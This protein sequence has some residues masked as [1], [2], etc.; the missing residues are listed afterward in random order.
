MLGD[1]NKD[2][3]GVVVPGLMEARLRTL[4]QDWKVNLLR[5]QL[6]THNRTD[7]ND[8]REWLEDALIQLDDFLTLCDSYVRDNRRSMNVIVDLHRVPGGFDE[9]GNHF[10][11]MDTRNYSKWNAEF[12]RTWAKIVNRCK[13]HRCVIGYDLFN[14][15]KGASALWNALAEQTVGEIR[16]RDRN[17][18]IVI[19]NE[20][21]NP[22]GIEY[23]IP[24][25]NK[26]R[27]DHNIWYSVHVY[28]PQRFTSQGTSDYPTTGVR[29]D[30]PAS[31]QRRLEIAKRE[32]SDRGFPIYVGEFSVSNAAP[33]ADAEKYLNDAIRTFESYGWHWTYHAY[34]ES[35]VWSPETGNRPALLKQRFAR[36]R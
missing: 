27:N 36:N 35:Q 9:K 5:W 1:L 30:G 16:R 29:Y 2:E 14:E 13:P 23:M 25:R 17:R 12:V 33:P 34:A 3:N 21:L 8:Y 26:L 10:I 32:F 28:D 7:I 31:F 6:V 22:R 15:P 19:E 4:D 24:L 11:L 20:G 18:I